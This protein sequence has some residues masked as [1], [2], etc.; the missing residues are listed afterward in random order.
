MIRLGFVLLML[1]ASCSIPA[2]DD[3]HRVVIPDDVVPSTA[4][5]T[6]DDEGDESVTAT[7]PSGDDAGSGDDADGQSGNAEDEAGSRR[8]ATTAT[9]EPT[10][11][12]VPTATPVPTPK[13]LPELAGA[14][15]LDAAVQ[16]GELA[17]GLR[18]FIRT[19]DSPG[20]RAELRLIINAGSILEDDDQLGGAHLLEHM[21]FN[22]TERFPANEL[23]DVLEGFGSAFGADINAYTSYD[24]TV[25]QL[26]IPTDNAELVETALDVLV[27]WAHKATLDP[28]QIEAERGVVI[29][30]WRLRQEGVSGRLFSQY[31]ELV[32]DGSAYSGHA[33]IGS[34]ESI[35][36]MTPD[37]LR[38]FYEDWYRPDL[39]TV[40]AVGDFDPAAIEQGIIER[41][42]PLRNPARTRTRPVIEYGPLEETRVVRWIDPDLTNAFAEITFPGLREP[43]LTRNDVRDD[44]LIRF[45]FE[46]ITNR[47]SDDI[48]RGDLP[49]V[50]VSV[51]QIDFGRRTSIP[52]VSIEASATNL[53]LG[54]ERMLLEVERARRFGFAEAE[55]SAVLRVNRAQADQTLAVSNTKQDSSFARELVDHA[56]G[57]SAAPSPEEIHASTIAVLDQITTADIL[58]ALQRVIEQRRGALFILGPQ[59]DASLIPTAGWFRSTWEDIDGVDLEPRVYADASNAELPSIGE[60]GSV[61]NRTTIESLD[62]TDVTFDNGLRVLIKPTKIFENTTLLGA[63]SQGGTS[64]AG[65]EIAP[66]SALVN[67][68]VNNSG[69]GDFDAAE[70]R[71]VLA[72]KF[73]AL[74][75]TLTIGDEGFTGRA[76][77]TDLETLFQLAN[78]Y[79]AD[80]RAD[81][82]ALRVLT[83]QLRPYAEDVSSFPS[84]ATEAELA[85][86]LYGDDPR[87]RAVPSEA[88][89]DDFDLQGA[90]EFFIDRFDDAGDFTFVLAGDVDVESAIDLSAR[91]LGTLPA[92]ATD[93][94]RTDVASPIPTGI[95]ERTVDV[96]AGDQGRF[97]MVFT[98]QY[99][100]DATGRITAQ[101]LEA[102]LSDR[103]LRRLREEL[104]A[105]YSPSVSVS[106]T[107]DPDERIVTRVEMGADPDRLDEVAAE[108]L[109][110]VTELRED[111]P[112]ATTFEATLA[113]LGRAFEL[114]TNEAWIDALLDYAVDPEADPVDWTRRG[115]FLRDVDADAVQALARVALSPDDYIQ[116][117]EVPAD[118]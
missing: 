61:A 30:E 96:G 116:I 115:V 16:S 118:Q 93:E 56:L 39:M 54:A 36:T 113:V 44:L 70:L 19:N 79:M 10:P 14:I 60:R 11:T 75:P 7:A 83:S 84:F 42:T 33:P 25:Y 92:G 85:D 59:E 48:A 22:G 88:T 6:V 49:L 104:G 12:I 37:A 107:E 111:G 29:E 101:V 51:E 73:V 3:A 34:E 50:G 46:M 27:E 31:D 82:T 94:R 23:L 26:T 69:I 24:E 8:S 74:A 28:E 35:K 15:P 103:L 38:R 47:L 78:M 90:H 21:M 110:A 53:E 117:L 4:E 9:P 109:A 99:S 20:S 64:L 87:R 112:D 108:T 1:V 71:Q 67:D 102:V 13:P 41:F 52:G 2:A 97:T 77:T 32:L 66:E 72:G 80:S 45:A 62:V 63:V 55:L 40:V 89:L 81:E 17:N 57:N 58:L 91:Y 98:Q 68:I 18:Y 43:R 105:T 114:T 5:A 95:I 106:L 76:S 100:P 65:D 86:I